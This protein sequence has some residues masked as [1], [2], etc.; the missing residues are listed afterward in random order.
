M[1]GDTFT[2]LMATRSS[3]RVECS[4][5]LLSYVI[6][7]SKLMLR[8]RCGMGSSLSAGCRLFNRLCKV[9]ESFLYVRRSRQP[10]FLTIMIKWWV[11]FLS[12][13]V[14]SLSGVVLLWVLHASV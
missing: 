6:V 11:L 4:E 9:V 8:S 3:L 5:S 12:A 13:S 1:A 2:V 14:L 7:R 10:H